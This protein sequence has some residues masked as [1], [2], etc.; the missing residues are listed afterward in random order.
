M[1]VRVFACDVG[2]WKIL[3]PTYIPKPDPS[4]DGR[5]GKG[6]S[7]EL[8]NVQHPLLLMPVAVVI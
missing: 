8:R 3:S 5:G 2:N 7:I 1:R 4:S 6:F